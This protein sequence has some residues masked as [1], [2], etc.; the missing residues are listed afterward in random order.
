MIQR[1]EVALSVLLLFMARYFTTIPRKE[2]KIL[3]PIFTIGRD[4][5]FASAERAKKLKEYFSE[6]R[7]AFD[8]YEASKPKPKQPNQSNV[9]KNQKGKKR[10]K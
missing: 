1:N 7:K 4:R 10:R 9:G 2:G 6:L 5:D 3:S 8:D